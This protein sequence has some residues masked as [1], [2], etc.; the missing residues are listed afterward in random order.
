MLPSSFV[1]AF[2]VVRAFG[3]HK[4]RV[5]Q[6]YMVD[7]SHKAPI[8]GWWMNIMEERKSKIDTC[9]GWSAVAD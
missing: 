1:T 5:L 7:F 2:E 4:N 9:G 6:I 8:V 3:C